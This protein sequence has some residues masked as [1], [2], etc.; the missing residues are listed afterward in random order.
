MPLSRHLTC[1]TGLAGTGT[2][3]WSGRRTQLQWTWRAGPAGG[4]PQRQMQ[5]RV[6]GESRK[7][8]ATR[9]QG[10]GTH[11]GSNVAYKRPLWWALFFNPVLSHVNPRTLTV[12]R[13]QLRRLDNERNCLCE[14]AVARKLDLNWLRI[15]RAAVKSAPFWQVDPQWHLLTGCR[16]GGYILLRSRII[17]DVL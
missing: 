8:W 15:R 2:P 13:T 5:P 10:H 6:K 4:G 16:A 3:P 12:T 11:T 17:E 7:N 9:V 1:D 14:R